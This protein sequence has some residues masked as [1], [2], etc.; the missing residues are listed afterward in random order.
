MAGI[1]KIYFD[2]YSDF[3]T[4]Y[5][6]C[7]L[8]NDLCLNDTNRSLLD[9]FYYTPEEVKEYL[10]LYGFV[11]FGFCGT[12]FPE[13]IDRWLY[14]HCPIQIIRDRLSEQYSKIG[15]PNRQIQ[16]YVDRG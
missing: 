4:F 1:D 8:F 3:N 7:S 5:Q 13:S 6:W 11:P 15:I 16:L 14:K 10:G 9:Y 2:S 12:N